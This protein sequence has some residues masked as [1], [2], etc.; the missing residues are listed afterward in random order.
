MYWIDVQEHFND[1]VVGTYG[2]GIWILDDLSPLQQL[3]QNITKKEAHLFD[4]KP[5]YRF[6]NVT[7]SLQRQKEAST[8]LSLIHI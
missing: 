3:D 1:L 6:Q 5:A 4:I 2:R 7:G 8:G